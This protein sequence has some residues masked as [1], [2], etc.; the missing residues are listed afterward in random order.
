MKILILI[1]AYNESSTIAG[2]IAS[3]LP[4]GHTILIIDDGSNDNTADL[5]HKAGATVISHCINL[6]QGAAL[7]TGL[8]Y[9]RKAHADIVITFDA[10]GQHHPADIALL[11][12]AM[13]T[14]NADIVLGSR[15]LGEARNISWIKKI[16]LKLMVHYINTTTSLRITDAHNGL[17]ALRVATTHNIQLKQNRM[18][19]ASELLQQ[20]E[21]YHLRYAEIPC[22]ITYTPYSVSKG[23]KISHSMNILADLFIGRLHK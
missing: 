18:A 10:D 15:F 22:T 16:I 6:G 17:R 4:L 3:L 12:E 14:K 19:H 1:P 8:E 2:V 23:Q 5:A 21:K 9:A 11:L 13:H 20:I 7:Q